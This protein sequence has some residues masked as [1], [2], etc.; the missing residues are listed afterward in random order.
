MAEREADLD[1]FEVQS[2]YYRAAEVL[3]GCKFDSSI[4][5]SSIGCILMELFLAS[6]LFRTMN[7]ASLCLQIHAILSQFPIH[8]YNPQTAKFY[9]KY[10]NKPS[11][12]T[13]QSQYSQLYTKR[14]EGCMII[15]HNLLSFCRREVAKTLTFYSGHS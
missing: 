5:I 11:Y 7:K 3:L 4:D 13:H 14:Y 9:K 2:L 1:K 12:I 8:L 15:L 10:F 6:P